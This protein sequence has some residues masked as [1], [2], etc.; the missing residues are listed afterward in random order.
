MRVRAS[1]VIAALLLAC[2]PAALAGEA[3]DDWGGFEEDEE[4][5]VEIDREGPAVSERWWDIDG[6]FGISTSINYFEH[7][8]VN[9]T[10]DP[11]A[12]TNWLGLSRLRARLNLE[13][14]FELPRDLELPRGFVLLRDWKLRLAPH[15]WYDFTYLIRGTSNYTR[16][17]LGDYEWEADVQDAYLEGPLLDDLDLKIGR[18]VV[19][20]GRS[21]TLRVLDVLNPLDN[22]EPGRADIEDLRRA[23]TMVKLDWHLGRS[24][25]ITGIAIPEMRFDDLPSFGTDFS[26]FE[27]GGLD[28]FLPPGIPPELIPPELLEST[29][30]PFLLPDRTEPHHFG[31]TEWGAAVSGIFEGWD[32]SFHFAG[33]HED[34]PRYA[35][36]D[37][38]YIVEQV[39]E[40]L[41]QVYDRILLVG[42]GGNY[43]FG[44]WLFKAEAA[45]LYGFEYAFI[46]LV[47]VDG[48]PFPLPRLDTTDEKSRLDVMGGVEYYGFSETTFALEVVNRHIFD[49]EQPML[50]VPS[51]VRENSVEYA[52]RYTADWFNARLSTTLLGIIFGWRG[53]DGAVVRAEG[54]YTFRDGLVGTLGILIY[55]DGDLPPLSLWGNN[56]RVFIDLKY[57]F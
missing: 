23:V 2:P 8:F 22:R 43:T 38:A 46:D 18:Q 11:P 55:E 16:E 44:S 49:Y 1:A 28:E 24:W 30:I 42:A 47:M 19:N 14:D 45:W 41:K 29:L 52:V 25:R 32:I 51:Y 26:A 57:S 5:E 9:P 13:F 37:G 15:F 50:S 48:I 17:V 7:E 53:Q 54:S 3:E 35:P 39:D 12:R 4:F 33:V 6:S 31:D 34:I 40:G 21:D 36:G 27:V 10:D 20:W 56:D